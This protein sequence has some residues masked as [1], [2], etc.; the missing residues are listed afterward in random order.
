MKKQCPH[1]GGELECYRNP[2]PTVDI[3]IEIPR[4]G[5]VLIKR[6]NKP[7]GWAIPGGFV[8][9]G[10]TLEEAAVREAFEE[11]GLKVELVRQW[12]TYSDP[13]RDPRHHT[14]TT[15]FIARADGEPAAADDAQEAGIF[16]A[17]NLPEPMA[18]DHRDILQD[19]FGQS[20]P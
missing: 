14:I 6:K 4:R 19:Y 8:D 7:F 20:A 9:Y 16:R 1:C 5:I 10:E 18:F 15:V 13:K 3:I 2:F 12:H 17:E 11:T